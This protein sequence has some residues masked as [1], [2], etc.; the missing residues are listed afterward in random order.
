MFKI[1]L[2]ILFLINFGLISCTQ[3]DFKSNN[4]K[5]S[6]GYIGGEYE[7]LLLSN[8]LT[9]HLESFEMLDE[10]SNLEIR[11]SV[12]HSVALYV[13]NIDNTSSRERVKS[14]IDAQ[15]FNKDMECFEY[16]FSNSVTQFYIYATNDK[17]VSNKKALQEIK[18]ANTE[19]LVKKLVN[20]LMY[21]KFKCDE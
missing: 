12:V 14:I 9:S 5:F 19:E 6:L 2:L 8:Y 7:G 13:T 16:N 10:R 17:F 3:G 18:T 11:A 20:S 15:V 1:K 4:L 21:A